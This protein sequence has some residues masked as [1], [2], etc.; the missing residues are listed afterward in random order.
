[1]RPILETA[2]HTADSSYSGRLME[3]E[4][5]RLVDGANLVWKYIP[6]LRPGRELPSYLRPDSH[7]VLRCVIEYFTD[8]E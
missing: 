3:C 8:H 7:D 4:A 6:K 2:P 5:Y 1:M